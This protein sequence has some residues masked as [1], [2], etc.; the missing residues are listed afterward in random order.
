MPIMMRMRD[1]MPVILFGLL[2][3]FLVMIVFEWGMD[4]L[5][6]R[7]GR[8]D[9]L[10]KI[11]GKTITYKEFSEL[12]RNYSAA[13]RARTGS[14]PDEA[15]MKQVREQIWQGLVTQNLLEERIREIG[16]KVTDQQLRNL[17]Q[18]DNPPEDLRQAFLD[19][20]G[21]FRRDLYEQF[22]HEPNQFVKDPEGADP[23]YGVR[24]F[25]QYQQR[26]REQKLQ[27]QL[28][29]MLLASVRVTPEELKQRFLDQNQTCSA[30]YCLFEASTL[31][32]DDDITVSDEDLRKYYD[33]NLD[34][35]RVDA[36]RGVKYVL[37]MEKPSA[38]D[39]AMQLKEIEDVAAKARS[40][41]DFLELVSAYSAKPDSGAFFRH[42][43]L[44]KELEEAVFA[45]PVGTTVGP[46]ADKEGYHL[47]KILEQRKSKTEYVRARHILLT[48]VGTTDSNQVKKRAD[49]LSRAL[50]QGADFASLAKTYS[51]DQSSG[52]LGGDLGYFTRGRMMPAFENAAFKGK[53]G[54]I[55]GPVRTPYGLHII[56]V[57]GRDDR[58]LKLAHIAVKVEPS[59]QTK[60]DLFE[61]ARDF[62]Y[63]AR[64]AEFV[65]ES[66]QMG[67]PVREATLQQKGG[68]IPGI[69]VDEGVTRWVFDNSVGSVSEPFSITGGYAIFAVVEAKDAGVRPF[70]DVKESLRPAVV[71]R[72][73]V[74]KVLQ[75]AAD[76]RAQLNSSDSLTKAKALN[77]LIDVRELSGFT[78]SSPLAGIGRDLAFIGAV[79]GLEVGKIS[80]PVES[81]RGAYLIQVLSRSPFDSTAFASQEESLRA[82]LLQE[83]RNTFLAEWLDA[84]KKAATIEDYRDLY[85]R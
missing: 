83:K 22:L 42:G 75:M 10:G 84:L 38:S 56:Q 57:T 77:P 13:Q 52:Q 69:G 41:V 16:A 51:S 26:L 78:A 50:R 3:A 64:G 62:A 35:Y 49:S 24:W 18:G 81:T 47:L 53:I 55:I 29:S 11:N 80:P 54:E 58:E 6:L 72:K 74:A 31:V 23:N 60:N 32:K 59:P 73:K 5:G 40:G 66:E 17:L 39:S 8:G 68:V 79:S 21:Q 15:Q 82:R 9:V 34:Q 76:V 44:S 45:S 19:S 25:A 27:E 65:K 36:T 7:S 63:N 12:L 20:T 2:I 30:L 85:Y 37:M 28:Q 4:Y 43:E 14:E 67:F 1:N 71:Q 48:L 70:A 33:D 61:R 46:V